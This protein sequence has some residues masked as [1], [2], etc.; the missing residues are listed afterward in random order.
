MEIAA[1]RGADLSPARDPVA[2]GRDLLAETLQSIPGIKTDEHQAAVTS[3]LH[4]LRGLGAAGAQAIRDF[5]A[6]GNDIALIEYRVSTA[7]HRLGLS[8][9]RK[10]LIH[11]LASWPDPPA[12]TALSRDLLG[13]TQDPEEAVLAIRALEMH[14]PGVYAAEALQALR[15][16]LAAQPLGSQRAAQEII[17]TASHY[18]ATEF[19]PHLERALDQ[20]PE[21]VNDYFGA[22][23]T[24]PAADRQAAVARV[25]A[26]PKVISAIAEDP[27]T[28]RQLPVTDPAMRAHIAGLFAT[29]LTP[30]QRE[31]YLF[32]FGGNTTFLWGLGLLRPRRAIDREQLAAEQAAKLQL[33]D[34]LAPSATTPVLQQRLAEARAQ[35]LPALPSPRVTL[36]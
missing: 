17:E 28:L 12:A 10:A 25:L 34:A 6:S 29:Q 35:L 2:D 15:E 9:L 20:W 4:R 1:A 14:A 21:L 31:R 3:L 19:V 26:N 13:A 32:N 33:I 8:T 5:L 36:A 22:L 11:S 27:S 16:L 7:S 18:Q 24:F 30:A 23:A